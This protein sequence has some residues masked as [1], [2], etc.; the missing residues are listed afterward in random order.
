MIVGSPL[1][2]PSTAPQSWRGRRGRGGAGC[3]DHGLP[4]VLPTLREAVRCAYTQP[5]STLVPG[6]AMDDGQVVAA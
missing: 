2:S 5:V 3:D 4:A 1:S 6:E